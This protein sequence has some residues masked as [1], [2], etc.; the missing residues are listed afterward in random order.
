MGGDNFPWRINDQPE[1]GGR[2]ECPKEHAPAVIACED[3]VSSDIVEGEGERGEQRGKNTVGIEA[4]GSLLLCSDDADDQND[5]SNRQRYRN[6][7]LQ[8]K[9]FLATS[10]H[11]E[12]NPYRSGVLHD[13]RRRNVCS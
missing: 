7:L 12:E 3:A 10:D 9:L 6:H 8:G 2:G 13:D 5:S 1:D 11:V 4:Q